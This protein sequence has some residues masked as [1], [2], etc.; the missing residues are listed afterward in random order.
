VLTL[1]LPRW[2]LNKLIEQVSRRAKESER[3]APEARR[4]AVLGEWRRRE[5]NPRKLSICDLQGF[6][7]SWHRPRV[8]LSS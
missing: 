7:S 2:H 1:E 4:D 8:G 5:L 3:D 6:S